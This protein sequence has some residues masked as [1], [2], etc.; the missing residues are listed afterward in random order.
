M[1]NSKTNVQMYTC[2][3]PGLQCGGVFAHDDDDDGSK[4]NAQRLSSSILLKLLTAFKLDDCVRVP[5]SGCVLIDNVAAIV[6]HHAT[7]CQHRPQQ[8]SSQIHS[9]RI[10]KHKTFLLLNWRAQPISN[11]E[12]ITNELTNLILKCSP[13]S[14]RLLIELV[15]GLLDRKSLAVSIKRRPQTKEL[16]RLRGG[17]GGERARDGQRD[18]C[19]TRHASN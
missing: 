7:H 10:H 6:L 12:C 8:R 18:E 5:V 16:N 19:T 1:G 3:R 4:F 13:H 15:A 14:P 17:C 2:A 9:G 11:M